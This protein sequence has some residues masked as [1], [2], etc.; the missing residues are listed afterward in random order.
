MK[1]INTIRSAVKFL[2]FLMSAL[3]LISCEKDIHLDL[4]GHESILVVEGWIEQGTVPKVLLSL[5]APFFTA[6][7]SSNL[8]DF[9]VTTAK[10]TVRSDRGEEEIL[11]LK[12][13]AVFFPPF[14]YFGSE[15]KGQ[16][17]HS[18]S[19]EIVFRGRIYTSHTSI[20]ELTAPDSTWFVKESENDTS[21]LIWLDF[22]DN[23]DEVNY[24]RTLTRR[25][26]KDARFIPTFT[27]VFSDELFNGET[28][29]ISLSRG[30]TSILDV[31]NDRFFHVGDT[32]ILRFCSVDA[33]H[34]TFWNTLQNQIISSANPFASSHARVIGNIEGDAIGIWGGYAASYDTI[35]AW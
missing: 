6:I 24:Y 11:T 12:P 20:P 28:L 1:L 13:N 32:I 26:T 29:Q 5:S 3:H 31:E 33:W 7:D 35:I 2:V 18:Y 14:Y 25:L 21:G 23:P 15:I 19:L 8:R 10:V 34:Y 9:G 30:N 27:S 22:T 4:P 17:G 16:C